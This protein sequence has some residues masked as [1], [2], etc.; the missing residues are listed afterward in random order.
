LDNLVRF[1]LVPGNRYENIVAAPLI[2]GFEFGAILRDKAFD[3]SWI[4]QDLDQRGGLHQLT[5]P[6]QTP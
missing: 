5:L 3:A 6:P 4:V 2:D 1:E